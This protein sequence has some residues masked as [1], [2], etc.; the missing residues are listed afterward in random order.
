MSIILD[1]A[2][3]AIL[4]ICIFL[5]YKRGFIRTVIDMVGKIAAFIAAWIFASPVANWISGA[6]IAPAMERGMVNNIRDHLGV[7]VDTVDIHRLFADMPTFIRNML[8]T[9]NTTPDEVIAALGPGSGDAA[10][11]YLIEDIARVIVG[12]PARAISYV[13][14]FILLFVVFLIAIMIVSRLAG[15]FNEIPILRGINRTA[16]LLLGALNGVILVFVLSFAMSHVLPYIGQ[17]GGNVLNSTDQTLVYH[18]FDR[19]NPLRM[20]FGGG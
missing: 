20:I 4:G 6:I 7:P 11:E 15:F 18:L 10:G 2:T 17:D 3:I 13:I 1:I 8:N 14:A 16:G 9:F 19:I 5:A 12:P